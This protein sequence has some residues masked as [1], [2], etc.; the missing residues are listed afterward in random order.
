MHTVY[1]PA[2]LESDRA[3]NV[4][5]ILENACTD[6]D[7]EHLFKNLMAALFE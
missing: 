6:K 3:D 2:D 1:I 4:I 7:S 5:R